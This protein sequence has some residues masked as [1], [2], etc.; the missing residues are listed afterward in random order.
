M[1]IT[2]PNSSPARQIAIFSSNSSIPIMTFNPYDFKFVD[3]FKPEFNSYEAF[4]RMDP[5]MI[6]KK[7]SRDIN[8]SFKVVA[9][10]E[11]DAENNF[12]TLNNLIQSM[13]PTYQSLE[14]NSP[15]PPAS[16]NNSITNPTDRQDS[17]IKTA[18]LLRMKFMN[19]LNDTAFL[20]AIN[21]FNY[22]MDFE[23]GSYTS[24]SQNG[25]AIPGRISYTIGFKVLHT[26]VPGTIKNVYG[27]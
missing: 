9:E 5:I 7:T 6:Y 12:K 24:L 14:V 10:N 3:S 25:V 8:L 11:G 4:G 13:Y 1:T 20:A 2:T 26:Y 27:F 18:P 23:N 22:E 16:A 15:Q 17:Y 19:L 21:T